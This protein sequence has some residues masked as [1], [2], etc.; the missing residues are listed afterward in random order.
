[1]TPSP[2]RHTDTPAGSND[3]KARYRDA[4]GRGDIAAAEQA[5]SEIG[6][7]KL[8][9]EHGAELRRMRAT[10]TATRRAARLRRML[11]PPRRLD[12]R[13]G[14]PR[15]AARR[16]STSSSRDGPDEPEPEP[17][18]PGGVH[19]HLDRHLPARWSA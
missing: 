7:P 2:T 19:L 6:G 11:K 13:L 8:G 10:C 12:R 14:C 9:R 1:M 17:R 15:P 3:A 5:M 16:T 18:R 4:F